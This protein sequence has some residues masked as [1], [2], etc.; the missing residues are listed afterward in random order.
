MKGRTGCTRPARNSP[1]E[2]WWILGFARQISIG[3]TMQNGR[4]HFPVPSDTQS[5]SNIMQT[6]HRPPAIYWNCFSPLRRGALT[7]ATPQQRRRQQRRRQQ[8]RRRQRRR[9]QRRRRQRRRQQR[10][11]RQ[12][13]RQQRRRQQRRRQQLCRK[14][15]QGD[16]GNDGLAFLHSSVLRILF[17]IL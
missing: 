13:R 16:P 17:S 9:Q 4:L 3:G 10:R 15:R 8:R 14:Q 7:E 2:E 6:P 5:H 12:R 11:R 1:N